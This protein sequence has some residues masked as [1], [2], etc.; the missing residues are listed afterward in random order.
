MQKVLSLS[1]VQQWIAEAKQEHLFV[2]FNEPYRSDRE[3]YLK[4]D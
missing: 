2:P 1:S 4:A 3:E